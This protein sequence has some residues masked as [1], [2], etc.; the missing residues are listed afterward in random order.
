MTVTKNA[1]LARPAQANRNAV[2]LYP[3]PHYPHQ[4]LYN[5]PIKKQKILLK[6]RNLRF[7][8]LIKFPRI[9]S[10]FCESHGVWWL[11]H[12]FRSVCIPR[13]LSKPMS[14]GMVPVCLF[15]Y[16]SILSI[17]KRKQNDV[18]LGRV[19]SSSALSC[20]TGPHT[21]KRQPAK[22]CR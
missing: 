11:R 9:H 2:L 1:S 18:A 16:P 10:S 20:K 13:F 21:K 12:A 8:S 17:Q 22:L 15:P 4:P 14:L 6:W 7:L 19:E 5:M 3:F